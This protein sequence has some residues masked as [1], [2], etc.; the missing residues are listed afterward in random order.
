MPSQSEKADTFLRLHQQDP[1][2]VL[3]NAWDVASARIFEETGFGAIAS[4]SAGIAAVLGYPDN[5]RVSKE[6]MLVAVKRI[7][8][9]VKVPVTADIEGGYDTTPSGT[10][11]VARE[12]LRAGV[13]GINIEDRDARKDAALFEIEPQAAR[14]HAVRQMADE[15]GV[16]LVI[17]ARTDVFLE[18]IGDPGTRFERTIQR[19]DAYVQAGADCIFIPGAFEAETISEFVRAIQAPINI[20]VGPTTLSLD[21]LQDLGV[22]RVSTGSG[23]SR[24]ALG[25]T[26]KLANELKVNRSL[27]LMQDE[28]IPYPEVNTLFDT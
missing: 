13:V 3:P 11:E 10:A 18:A 21:T 23:L 25:F 28:A 27:Q 5:Q 7:A 16:H 8:E 9:G 12:F 2:L 15:E 26:R 19:A 4:T 14:I 22:S 6:E 24:A 20:L 17:N 1:M